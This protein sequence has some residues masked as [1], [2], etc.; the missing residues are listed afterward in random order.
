MECIAVCPAQNTLQFSLPP[1]RTTE[2]ND[3]WRNLVLT[4]IAV[5]IFLAC[6]FFRFV[7]YA[8]AIW[9]WNTTLPRS[10]Y[11]EL[12]PNANRLSHPGK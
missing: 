11:A 10:L 5:T 8:K 7:G 1:R 4:P 6:I 9:H 3:R 12:V 2:I